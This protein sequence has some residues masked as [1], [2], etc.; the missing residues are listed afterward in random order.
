MMWK[1]FERIAGY[2]VSYDDYVNYIEPMYMGLPD[3][4][5]KQDFV[6]MIDRKRFAL[7]DPRGILRKIRKEARHLYEICG[8]YSDNESEHRLEALTFQYA[9][10]K[11]G[12]DWSKDHKVYVY[13]IREYEFPTIG[14]GCTYPCTLVIGREG[15]GEFARIKL[16]D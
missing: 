6:Q 12:L 13:C 11:Y 16:V 15:V 2:E 1:E 4:V 10:R 3:R 8:H 14:R 7:P 9:L 5:S